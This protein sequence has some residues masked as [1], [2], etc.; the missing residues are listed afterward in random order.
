M[1]KIKTGGLHYA[2]WIVI[3]CICMK[4]GS[5]AAVAA[6]MSNFITPIVRDLGC[7]VSA[8]T[9]FV[10]IEAVAMALMYTTASKILTTRK[11]GRVMGIA[12]IVELGG[13]ALMSTYRSVPMFYF[14]GLLIGVAQAFTGFVAIPILLNMWFRKKA[15]T[16]LGVVVAVS[17]AAGILYNLLSAQLI[18]AF[19]WRTAYLVL[20][21][22]GAVITLPAVFLIIKSPA[23]VGCLPYGAEEAGSDEPEKRADWAASEWGLTRRQAFSSLFLY[24]AW[25]ACIMYS[26]G[27]GVSG[28]TATYATMELGQSINFGA[29]A[30][31]ALSIGTIVSSLIL[32]WINDRLGVRAGLVWGAVTTTLG[33]VLMLVSK[34]NPLLVLPAAFT[35][36]LGSS[37]YTVQCPLLA[38]S[39][40]G[41]KHYSE[42]WSLMMMANS[43]IGGGLYS[44]IGLF[45]DK[46][47]SYT[48]AFIMAI[49]LYVGALVVGALAIS[50]AG[51]HKKAE[52]ELL[53][54]K[55]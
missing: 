17:G 7:E 41:V 13:L 52:E 50:L 29:Y 15:G 40:V 43:L 6:A 18:T 25:L 10:S 23:E 37:M 35:V 48:G 27:S 36:G 42:I 46:L 44:S 4:I 53:K 31:I 1:K 54:Q 19:G 5:S 3:A 55:L 28:Y 11:I 2:W 49:A 8:L 26:Y 22:I 14:S 30:G 9:T 33:Y 38:R 32:G 16:V 51:R 34:A 45:Y 24:V 12:S 20:A 39:I 21:A 47:G